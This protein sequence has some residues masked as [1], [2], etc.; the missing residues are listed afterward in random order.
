MKAE[1]SGTDF[2]KMEHITNKVKGT[3]PESLFQHDAG[4]C[5][6]RTFKSYCSIQ[7]SGIEIS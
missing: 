2:S 1:S 3:L 4:I 5:S 7:R 6:G